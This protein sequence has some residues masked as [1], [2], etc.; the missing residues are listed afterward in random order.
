MTESKVM[1]EVHAIRRDIYER[2]KD[3][4]AQEKVDYY[5]RSTEET[6]KKYGIKVGTPKDRARRAVW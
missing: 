5:N 1:Q 2:T 6:I 3:M 4:T